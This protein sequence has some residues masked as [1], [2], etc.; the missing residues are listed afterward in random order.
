[1]AADV[2]PLRDRSPVEGLRRRG[3]GP[4]AVF[5]QSVS[6]AAPSAAMAATPVIVAASAGDA[7]VVSFLAATL[8][9]LLV[10]A[11]IGQFTRRMAA[12]GGLYTLTAK[13]LPPGAA[14]ACAVGLVV[15]YGLLAGGALAGAGQYL[16]EFA[17]MLGLR[18]GGPGTAA[19]VV[20]VA[21]G[22][23]VLVRRGVRLSARVVL[24]VESAA[25]GLMVA[26]F[27]LLLV[28]GPAPGPPADVPPPTVGGIAAGVVPAIA[29]FIGFEV[30]TVL[31]AEAR[32]PF[33]SVPRAVGAT[34]A[35]AGVLYLFAAQ[36]QVFGFATTPGGLAAQQDPVLTLAVARG[37]VWVPLVLDVALVAS[38]LACALASLTAL[39][40]VL[41]SL[42][43]DGVAPAALGRAHPRHHTPHVALVA[44]VPV[45]VVL[46]GAVAAGVP[47]GHL[48]VVLIT[49]ATCGFL[50][51]YVLVCA[52]APL[53]L[54]RIGELTAGAV[55]AAAVTAPVLLVALVAFVVVSPLPSALLGA[56][57]VLGLAWYGWVRWARPAELAGIGVYDET[58]STDVLGGPR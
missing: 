41:F 1:M 53:F 2:P 57:A 35:L 6:G 9:M 12:P 37:W 34:A 22:A 38:F 19:V 45:V 20:V 39:S 27:A 55:G 24:L 11:C 56:L 28:N 16:A 46:A 40:R 51:S 30:A 47:I 21:A 48:L 58:L 25:I 15:G 31:G 23:A 13:G 5:A 17:A 52:A 29:A 32:R 33:R 14:F 10:A 43:K 42:A 49:M 4:L 44:I 36:T 54:R 3:L 26:V 18:L 8:L 7:T 50:V